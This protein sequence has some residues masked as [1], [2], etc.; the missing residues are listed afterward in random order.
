MA[1]SNYHRFLSLQASQA[2]AQLSMYEAM[3]PP[4]S[5]PGP[6]PLPTSTGAPPVSSGPLS[7]LLLGDDQVEEIDPDWLPT[8]V[9]CRGVDCRY[10][11]LVTALRTTPDLRRDVDTADVIVLAYG[12]D[13]LSRV[14]LTSQAD[15]T[16]PI[17]SRL[18]TQEAEGAIQELRTTSTKPGL[19]VYCMEALPLP[20]WTG[21]RCLAAGML[22]DQ[23]AAAPCCNGIITAAWCP[24]AFVQ[25]NG[26]LTQQGYKAWAQQLHTLMWRVQGSPVW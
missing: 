20:H 25:P 22:I 13:D 14:V 18:I 4:A 1:F 15:A 21:E 26:D 11:H 16:M 7:L 17:P 10:H 24:D 9:Y 12:R 19:S 2:H 6:L 23:I 3:H 8:N 5:G